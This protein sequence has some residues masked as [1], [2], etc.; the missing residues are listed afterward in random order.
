[1]ATLLY[2]H[3]KPGEKL[4]FFSHFSGK[5]STNW[6][7]RVRHTPRRKVQEKS[8]YLVS[9]NIFSNKMI[10]LLTCRHNHFW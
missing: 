1:M 6:A 9:I 2:F 8:V 10:V 3:L 7:W 5:Q 4:L